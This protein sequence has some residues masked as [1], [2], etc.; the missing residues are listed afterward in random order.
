MPV[1]TIAA[2]VPA[3][4]WA[5]LLLGRGGFWRVG[6]AMPPTRPAGAQLSS[7]VAVV[8][9][10]R[11]EASVIGESV[12][13]LLQTAD[14]VLH[15]FV[16]D[17]HSSDGTAQIARQA[18]AKLGKLDSVTVLQGA[19]LPAGWS[20]KLWAVSQG[21][22]TARA[23][24]PDFLLLTDADVV[25]S[26]ATIPTLVSIAE[27][28]P[29]DVASF[30]VRLQCRSVAEKLLIPAFVFFFFKLYPPAWISDPERAIAAAAGGCLLIRPQ[31]L[32][33]AGGIEA[34]RGQIIDDCALAGAVKR[35]GGR[36]WLGL[37]E[38]SVSIRSYG[39]FAAIEGMISRTAF[40]QL[41][42]STFLLLAAVAGLAITYL[43]PPAL[44]LSRQASTMVVAGAAWALMTV[45][46]LSMIRFYKLNPLWA[47]T[48]P[49]AALFYAIATI[50]SAIKFWRGKGGEWKGR[51]QDPL[52]RSVYGS[53]Q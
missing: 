38:T 33:Q 25:H 9:P 12:A 18:A 6:R 49:V 8:I 40:N 31:A 43:F 30:M 26:L 28:G 44:L 10:A 34:I 51:A 7:R 47:L 36:V 5:Y 23:W 27:N 13:S 1:L 21:V 46:Y 45:A 3:L 14:V 39:S 20:G 15:V 4:I 11:D 42:H 48:L 19:S 29:Y 16:V 37:S 41:Q 24:A 35:V 17:D 2:V 32:A 53:R 52:Q 22:Q 50:H